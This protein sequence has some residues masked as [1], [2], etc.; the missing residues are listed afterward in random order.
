MC[1]NTDGEKLMPAVHYFF[2]QIIFKCWIWTFDFKIQNYD[3]WPMTSSK[4]ILMKVSK[5][6]SRGTIR[7][8]Y[9]ELVFQWF[10]WHNNILV[11]TP[12]LLNF[13][14][15]YR[16]VRKLTEGQNFS[17]R[18]TPTILVKILRLEAHITQRKVIETA[19]AFILFIN[20]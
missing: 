9:K 2:L 15:F 20:W 13:T 10:F 6:R 4:Q 18:T 7:N 1:F 17:R 5:K 11:Q 14:E 16:K 19:G 12:G 8:K 3:S